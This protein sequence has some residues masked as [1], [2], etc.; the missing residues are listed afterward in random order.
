MKRESLPSIKIL[1]ERSTGSNFL[2]QY[3]LNNFQI[4][5]FKDG[6][7]L[8]SKQR[9]FLRS[10][11]PDPTRRNDL[12]EAF[13]DANHFR[14]W[15]KNGGWKHAAATQKFLDGFVRPTNCTVICL[16]RHPA[17]W[18]HSMHRNPFHALANV[19]TN[20]SAFI[21]APWVCVGRD[22]LANPFLNNPIELYRSKVSSYLWLAEN[23]PNTIILRYEEMVLGA[24]ELHKQ[25]SSKFTAL[26]DRPQLPTRSTRNFGKGHHSLEEYQ[27]NARRAAYS[28]LSD[29]DRS[30][31]IAQLD[32]HYLQ[33]VYPETN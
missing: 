12:R 2:E 5:T 18:L 28:N 25:L 3:L 24:D 10:A 19:P 15:K 14:T 32:E 4:Q 1:G 16:I 30:F 27:A 13:R 8:T 21:R 33:E 22:E 26:G 6:T 31:V 7:S 20:F 29:E 11:Q 9:D 23:Y 17:S